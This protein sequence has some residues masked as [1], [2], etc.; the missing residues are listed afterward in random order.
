[1]LI[2]QNQ[3][4]FHKCAGS[5]ELAD[6]WPGE[7]GGSTSGVKAVETPFRID[8][9]ERQGEVAVRDSV[10]ARRRRVNHLVVREVQVL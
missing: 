7:L 4:A 1:M 5:K 9:E 6:G 10:A 3:I 8:M 2:S